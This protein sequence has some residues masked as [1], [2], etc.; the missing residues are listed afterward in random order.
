MVLRARLMGVLLAAAALL[1]PATGLATTF[2]A[3]V[4]AVTIVATAGHIHSAHCGH[5]RVYYH[6]GWYYWVGGSWDYWN[7]VAHVW[8]VVPT[9][10]AP[11]YVRHF[12]ARAKVYHPGHYKVWHAGSPHKYVGPRGKGKAGPHFKGGKGR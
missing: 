11:V 6:G 4:A 7:P 9:Y 8:V 1:V 5:Y 2:P 10:R 12:E 3:P